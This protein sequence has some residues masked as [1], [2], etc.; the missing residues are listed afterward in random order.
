MLSL[1]IIL[2][3]YAAV[4][5]A[6]FVLTVFCKSHR[7]M[8][9]LSITLPAAYLAFTLYML[10]YSAVPTYS[11]GGNYFLVDHLSLYE[12]IISAFLFLPS[13]PLLSRLHRRINRNP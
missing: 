11:L 1:N 7:V 4:G 8:N 6:V 10:V 5:A 3:A 12:I 2:A 9:V 13:C